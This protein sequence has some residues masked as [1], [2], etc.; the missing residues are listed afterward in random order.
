MLALRRSLAVVGLAVATAVVL[1]GCIKFD[2][3]LTVTEKDTVSGQI[4]TGMS[5]ALIEMGGSSASSDSGTSNLFPEGDGITEVPFDDGTFVGST[6]Q[7]DEVPLA[8]FSA[9]D[10]TTGQIAIVRDGD[11]LITT[12]SFDLGSSSSADESDAMSMEMIKSMGESAQMKIAITYPGEIVSTNGVVDGKTV[13]W[14]P[15][16][17]ETT[18]IEAVVTAPRFNA[19][20]VFIGIGI[21]AIVIGAVVTLLLLRRKRATVPSVDS[22]APEVPTV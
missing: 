15:K 5:K 4:T 17:G 6:Y 9:S 12:G 18:V 20:P 16:F 8:A 14:T 22:S 10:S 11:N 2:V 3:E 1:T 13:T 19:V 21:A 7:F